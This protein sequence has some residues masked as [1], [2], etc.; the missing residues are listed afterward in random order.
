MGLR[1]QIMPF[2][3]YGIK[4]GLTD[5]NVQAITRDSKGLLWIGTDFGI[6][7]FDGKRFYQP[8]IKTAV[9]Q[10]YVTGFYKDWNGT[11]WVLSFFNGIYKYDGQK[12]INYLVNPRLKD[13]TNNSVS[14]MTQISKSL[15]LVINLDSPYVFDGHSFLP[16]DAGNIALAGKTNCV[17][18]LPDKTIVIGTQDG[19]LIYKIVNG[20]PVLLSRQYRGLK[21]NKLLPANGRFYMLTEQTTFMFPAAGPFGK[22]VP[23]LTD[24]PIKDI[25]G[26]PDGS[27]WAVA[28]NGSF[29]DIADSVFRIRNGKITTYSASNGLSGNIQQIYCDNEGLVWFA[30]RKGVGMLGDE[31][32]EFK[33]IFNGHY[34]NPVTDLVVDREHTLW[35]GTL[36]GLVMGKDNRFESKTLSE[37]RAI[38]YV[39]W[40]KRIMGGRILAGT[41]CG[42]L[43]VNAKKTRVLFNIH[44][45]AVCE[46]S[47][48]RLWFG[49]INGEVWSYNGKTLTQIH[50]SS[51]SPEMITAM[52]IDGRGLWLGYRDK[53]LFLYNINGNSISL[54]KDFGPQSG[55]PDIRIRCSAHD[56]K[57]NLYWGTRT[58][59]V[60]VFDNTGKPLAHIS[61]QNGLSAN[62]VR[63]IY[64]R[65]GGSL[66]LA[67]NNGVNIVKGDY[68]H[69]SVAIVKIDDDNIN[70]ETNCIVQ[71]G[72]LFYIGTNEGILKWMPRNMHKDTVPPPIY[73]T[74]ID[75]QGMKN[76]SVSPYTADGKNISLP[77]D[78]HF[79]SFEFAGISL[80]DPDKVSYRYI[81]AGQD[82]YWGQLTTSR[83]VSYDLRPGSYTFK[84]FAKNASG[85]WSR[86]PAVFRFTINPPF[87]QS[88]WFISLVL[89]LFGAMVYSAYRYRLS[90][91]LA[92]QLLRNRISTDLHDD[93]GSTLSSI[94]ILSEVAVNEK[95]KRSKAMLAE[96]NERTHMLMEKMDDIVWSIS[97]RNDTVGNLFSRIQQFASTIF[98]ARDIN[99]EVHIPE[100]VK[101][102]KL[103]MQSRQHIYL[104]LK[105]AINNLVKYSGCRNASIVAECTGGCLKIEVADDGKGFDTLCESHG[106]G[107]LNMKKRAQSLRAEFNI[108]STPGS[109]TWVKL[110]VEID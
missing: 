73:L 16:F 95:E 39:S 87:W 89:I 11:I 72:L 110:I 81:L 109:G 25:S 7:W 88:W 40:E 100:K 75:I 23:Y 32:Y 13:V 2:K 5:N 61:T 24:K 17:A 62:W 93:I 28:N 29:W 79:I 9:G 6:S 59:G 106:N 65:G 47:T 102:L 105:E 76:F 69:P 19:I 96:I 4:D 78:K 103:D 67:T 50:Q 20:K 52:E 92:L 57:G 77:Y 99:Y 94:S 90:K 55:Y 51:P 108:V 60:F 42:V 86:T 85:V 70:R 8:A 26:G 104:I 37:G 91:M 3:N 34:S 107:L 35:V 43:D 44:S 58:N 71:D 12:F 66:Y 31:V 98:E 74:R 15:Y 22:P 68:N 97:T 14:G 101:D 36:A 45:T 27:L 38:G 54:K 1:A 84:V 49:G 46:D 18:Q 80:K 83:D 10:L 64:C 48:G 30:N 41:V 63:D 33:R 56:A 53:G 82:K 21:V